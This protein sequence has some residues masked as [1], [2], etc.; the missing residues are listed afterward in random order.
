MY[1]LCRACEIVFVKDMKNNFFFSVRLKLK[2]KSLKGQS[3]CKKLRVLRKHV[4]M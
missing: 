2:E 3:Q 4:Q 1:L